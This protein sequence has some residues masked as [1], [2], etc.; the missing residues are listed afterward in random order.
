M[1]DELAAGP[2]FGVETIH[3]DLPP[4]VG[5][6]T[7]RLHAAGLPMTPARAVDLARS[8][9]LVRPVSRARLYWTARAVFVSDPVQVKAFDAVFSDVFGDRERDE[10]FEQDDA[11][12]VTTSADDRPVV[13]HKT[14][15]R[16]AAERDDARQSV[17]SAPAGEDDADAA[18]VDV[19]LAM[20]SDDEVL[21]TRSFDGRGNYTFGIK[22]QM[23]FPEIDF[24]RV[25]KIHGMD[26]TLV[27]STSR[28]DLAMGLLR[29]LG[30]PFRGETPQRVA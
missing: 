22:E 21:A 27:S 14:S 9:A 23:I 29:E 16:E 18:E 11:A 20:A 19:P 25:E 26:I 12:A 30:W 4:L 2:T 7:R 15:S 17:A 5:A 10:T 1:T 28:D 24:D 3:L 6:F 13:D 8:L